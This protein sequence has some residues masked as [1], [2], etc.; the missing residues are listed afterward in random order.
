MA[1]RKHKRRGFK[2]LTKAE[3][4]RIYDICGGTPREEPECWK[5]EMKKRR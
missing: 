5:R 3:Y 4:R 2:P 1:R